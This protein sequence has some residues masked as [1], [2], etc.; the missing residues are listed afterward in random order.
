[1]AAKQMNYTLLLAIA[2]MCLPRNTKAQDFERMYALNPMGHIQI[3]T[4]SGDVK[5]TGYAG[6]NIWVTG[7]KEGPDRDLVRIE[8]NNR[9]DKLEI[10]VRYPDTGKCNASIHIEIRVPKSTPYI[11]DR[12][13][14]VSGHVE[15][16]DIIGRLNAES[17]SGNVTVRNVNFI[18]LT[19]VNS[20]SGNLYVEIP[21]LSKLELAPVIMK[22]STISG[23][24]DVKASA[25]LDAT[26]NMS[27]VHGYHMNTEFPF[28]FIKK[29]RVRLGSGLN[30]LT[31]NTVSGRINLRRLQH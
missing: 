1:M 24:I 4:I 15:I 20:V 31:L 8:E 12:I 27:S 16:N 9:P 7:T 10:K 14:S 3:S 21:K 17:V 25:D 28:E 26:I 18:G 2:I 29:P 30:T 22:L 6:D 19:N 11:F 23:K 5:I 13:S